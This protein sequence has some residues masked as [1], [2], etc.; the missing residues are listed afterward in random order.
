MHNWE[1]KSEYR[2]GKGAYRGLGS[3]DENQTLRKGNY[4]EKK[5]DP[6]RKKGKK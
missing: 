2:R 4:V 3:R 1:I 6:L 5:K